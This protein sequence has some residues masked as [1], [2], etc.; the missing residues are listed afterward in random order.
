M[1][2]PGKIWLLSLAFSRFAGRMMAT[3]AH[4]SL[5]GGGGFSW[6]FGGDGSGGSSDGGNSG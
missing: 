4:N 6:G 1:T 2:G 3:A 5:P